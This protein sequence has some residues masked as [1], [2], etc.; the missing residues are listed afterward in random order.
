MKH[1]HRSLGAF[2]PLDGLL[3][4]C[5]YLSVLEYVSDWLVVICPI[6]VT[7]LGW[8][9]KTN[10][11]FSLGVWGRH[12]QKTEMLLLCTVKFLKPEGHGCLVGLCCLV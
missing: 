7:Q 10:S 5:H 3:I 6:T 1:T 12:F 2:R 9:Y 11:L 8:F 4:I